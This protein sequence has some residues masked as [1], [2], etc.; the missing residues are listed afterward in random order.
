M[1]IF[2]LFFLIAFTAAA[3]GFTQESFPAD[4]T[5]AIPGTAGE[6]KVDVFQD[7]RLDSIVAMHI[8]YNKHK[9]GI[10]GYRIQIFFDAGN[11]SLRRANTAAEEYQMLYPG[12][13][14]YISFSEPYYKVRVGDFRSRFEAEVYLQQI[15]GD[16]PNAFVIRDQINFPPL[17]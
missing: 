14:A 17:D 4:K 15:L 7:D 11:Y 10:D 8:R 6:G 2:V 5:T 13:T 3:P 1:K 12:D 16:Y 9:D